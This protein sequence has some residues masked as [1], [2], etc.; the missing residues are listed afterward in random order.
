MHELNKQI[1][2]QSVVPATWVEIRPD[3]RDLWTGG[4]FAITHT[5]SGRHFFVGSACMGRRLRDNHGWLKSGCHKNHALQADWDASSEHFRW[6]LVERCDVPCLLG[7][8][9]QKWIDQFRPL[10]RCYNAKNS[11]RRR[12]RISA[13]SVVS[14][15]PLR[16]LLDEPLPDPTGWYDRHV[17]ELVRQLADDPTPLPSSPDEAIK[18]A[19]AAIERAKRL[20][21]SR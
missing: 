7:Y 3:Q 10:D 11:T 20:L 14:S 17:E 15:L 16:P 5:V 19:R 13:R 12:R 8:T 4:V 18:Q 1:T 21:K 2:P 6:F 9:K